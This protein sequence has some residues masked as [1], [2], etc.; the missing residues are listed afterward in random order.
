MNNFQFVGVAAVVLLLLAVPQLLYR[1]HKD[2]Y[3][4]IAEDY[5]KYKEVEAAKQGV[6]VEEV[7]IE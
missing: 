1:S 4:L 5:E 2:T 6:P 7:V 3:F